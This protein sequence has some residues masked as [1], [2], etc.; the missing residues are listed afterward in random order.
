MAAIA[1]MTVETREGS[2]IVR[3]QA[4]V[5]VPQ[6]LTPGDLL[7]RGKWEVA[8]AHLGPRC[9]GTGPRSFAPVRTFRIQ[10]N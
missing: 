7:L 8:E 6:A 3:D 2:E 1:A 9:V 10:S 4:A 5:A